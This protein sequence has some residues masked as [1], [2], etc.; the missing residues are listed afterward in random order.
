MAEETT[1]PVESTPSVEPL[2]PVSG[3]A[4]A[5]VAPT[6]APDHRVL[7]HTYDDDLSKAMN[8][9]DAK[10]VQELLTNARERETIMKEEV[11]KRKARG[12]YTAGSLIL[13][14]CALAATAYGVYHYRRLTVPA[15]T[16][17]SIGVFPSTEPI[18]AASTTIEQLILDFKTDQGLLKAKPY[19]VD[20]V[21]DESG[22]VLLTNTELFSFIKAVPSEPFATSLAVIRLGMITIG[23]DTVP[24]LIASVPNPEI[25]A[26]EFLIA[27]PK[28]L[29]LFSAALDIDTTAI[30]TETNT[31]FVGEYRY[32]LP[33]RAL[34]T[35][36]Q[37]GARTLTML[38]GSATDNIIVITTK[39]DILKTIYD[40]VIRQQ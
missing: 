18:V 6:P 31:A 39:P 40:T 38:Y 32:N 5:P 8:V 34:Y 17:V 12:W 30:T 4:D 29:E 19:L 28:F 21:S 35:T 1:Q 22:Q 23:T 7:V 27:E 26:K 10:V 25:A 16:S 13:I 20:L 3:A 24:F 14:L 36:N 9:S 15:S 33:V 2:A 11:V 37:A